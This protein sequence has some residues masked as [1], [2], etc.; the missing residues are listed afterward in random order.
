MLVNHKWNDEMVKWNNGNEYVVKQFSFLAPQTEVVA[1]PHVIQGRLWKEREHGEEIFQNIHYQ[2]IRNYMIKYQKRTYL[3]LPKNDDEQCK[4]NMVDTGAGAWKMSLLQ[5][6][7]NG[8][9]NVAAV[10]TGS[11]K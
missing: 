4:R 9:A 2:Q 11:W 7:E 6:H 10:V 5:D 3:H 8:I 1:Y